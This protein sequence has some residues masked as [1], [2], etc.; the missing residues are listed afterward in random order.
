MVKTYQLSHKGQYG[1]SIKIA[2]IT[3]ETVTN[4]DTCLQVNGTSDLKIQ[5]QTILPD[6]S[7]MEVINI[8]NDISCRIYLDIQYG[9]LYDQYDIWYDS[10]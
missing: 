2:P 5:P 7:E 9:S 1:A 6:T 8:Y 4:E 10:L 3:T